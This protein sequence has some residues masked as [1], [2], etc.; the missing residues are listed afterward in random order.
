M[1]YFQLTCIA[2]DY[3]E[4][5]KDNVSGWNRLPKNVTDLKSKILEL[6]MTFRKRTETGS[7]ELDQ[8]MFINLLFENWG[9]RQAIAQIVDNDKLRVFGLLLTIAKN[10]YIL[11]RLS[12]GIKDR[13][14]LD[15]PVYSIKAMFQN[16]VLDYNNEHIHVK[17]PPD[18]E[19]L[20]DYLTLDANDSSRMKILRDC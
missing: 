9:G 13:Q 5:F 8:S 7:Y 3:M 10:K 4:Y 12:E 14:Q 17:L 2:I 20:D 18:A 15:D 1:Y 19:E 11:E 16:L 6:L